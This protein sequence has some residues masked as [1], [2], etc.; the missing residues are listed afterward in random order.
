MRYACLFAFS[1][2]LCLI[3]NTKV[4]ASK[5]LDPKQPHS[6][7]GAFVR[8][9]AVCLWVSGPCNDTGC[10]HLFLHSAPLDV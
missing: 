4:T 3:T 10:L 7:F 1:I 8:A 9:S 6:I 2:L 5:L